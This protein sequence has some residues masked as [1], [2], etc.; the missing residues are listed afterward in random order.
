MNSPSSLKYKI[1]LALI[2]ISCI[3]PILGFIIPFLGFSIT[4]TT[5]LTGFFIVGAPELVFLL[6]VL[7]AG[8]EAITLIKG[9]LL[10]PAGKTRYLS[11]LILFIAT[12]VIQWVCVYLELTNV[13]GL[14]LHGKLYL[15]GSLD[16]IF[17]LSLLL[18]GPEF[19]IKFKQ[20]FKWEG[21]GYDR[22]RTN[23]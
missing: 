6:G 23:S 2:V 4:V 17:I 12:M 10:K 16:L 13:I 5:F 20:I 22:E 9:K 14:G 8:K 21:V 3:M 15:M 1:G 18:M 11:G 7:L 19:F